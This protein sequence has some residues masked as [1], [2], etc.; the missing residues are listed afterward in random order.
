MHLKL[1]KTPFFD[2]LYPAVR[3]LLFEKNEDDSHGD[4]RH[5]FYLYVWLTT[6][7]VLQSF[8]A[9]LEE[10]II[11][12]YT[13]HERLSFGKVS[14]HIINRGVTERET[15]EER[16]LMV[17]TMAKISSDQFP[18]LFRAIS[19][20]ARGALVPEITLNDTE[21]SYFYSLCGEERD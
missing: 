6:E 16:A 13:M 9:V 8:Q 3:R 2:P 7:G 12:N 4:R 18:S 1:Y 11:L 5:D 15:P 21:R 20:V 17:E 14:R 10:T 19:K